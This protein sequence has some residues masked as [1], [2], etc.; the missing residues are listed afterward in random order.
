MV[1]PLRRLFRLGLGRPSIRQAVEWE[2]EHYLEEQTDRLMDEGLSPAD[3]R[4]EAERRFGN[5]ARQRK[6][7][8]ATDRRRVVMRKRGEF[9]DAI[10]TVVR[11]EVPE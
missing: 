5:V 4:S 3:A 10:L 2:I 11:Q 6:K 9:W 1:G 7:I 8:V